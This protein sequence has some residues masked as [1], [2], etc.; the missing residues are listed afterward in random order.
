MYIE[1]AVVVSKAR[2]G[3]WLA[4]AVFHKGINLQQLLRAQAGW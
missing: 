3:N 1:I 2:I 4:A